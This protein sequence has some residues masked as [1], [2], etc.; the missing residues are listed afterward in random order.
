MPYE[1]ILDTPRT[2]YCKSDINKKSHLNF[3][4]FESLRNNVSE[5]ILKPLPVENNVP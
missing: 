3:S 4:I 1:S 2:E 5:S